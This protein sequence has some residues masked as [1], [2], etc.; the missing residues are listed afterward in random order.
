[1]V[2]RVITGFLIP[3]ETWWNKPR[4]MKQ[5]WGNANAK[6]HSAKMACAP[7][8]PEKSIVHHSVNVWTVAMPLMVILRNPWK[9]QNQ[10]K[11]QSMKMAKEKD[12]AALMNCR[13]EKQFQVNTILSHYQP[14]ISIFCMILSVCPYVRW[15]PTCCTSS[16]V[17]PGMRKWFLY[18]S[19]HLKKTVGLL[20]CWSVGLLACLTK[21]FE[22]WE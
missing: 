20:A 16:L 8:L 22:W 6:N 21:L 5:L 17:G 10:K 3:K 1:M 7:V 11:K 2:K 9:N 4:C 13:E 12:P 19:S 15:G 14:K 18:A